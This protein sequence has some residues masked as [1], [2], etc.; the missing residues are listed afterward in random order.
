MTILIVDPSFRPKVAARLRKTRQA[1]RQKA[2]EAP[3]P[4]AN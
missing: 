2:M 3:V 4:L 1:D